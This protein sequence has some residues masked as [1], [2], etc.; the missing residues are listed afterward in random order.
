MTAS[1]ILTHPVLRYWLRLVARAGFKIV[2]LARRN[3]FVPTPAPGA[4]CKKI[5]SVRGAADGK[6]LRV[7][8]KDNR[9]HRRGLVE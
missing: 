2:S 6:W 3:G 7:A 9:R 5:P 1:I 8:M 4:P